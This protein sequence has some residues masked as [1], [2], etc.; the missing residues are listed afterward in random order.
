ME[1]SMKTKVSETQSTTTA[2]NLVNGIISFR[3]ENVPLDIFL[4]L[5][6]RIR[7]LL[8]AGP[9]LLDHMTVEERALVVENLLERHPESGVK[10]IPPP[11]MSQADASEPS[12]PAQRL[13][14]QPTRLPK[15]Y[16]HKKMRDLLQPMAGLMQTEILEVVR[17]TFPHHKHSNEEVMRIY[18]KIH[19]IR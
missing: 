9:F 18:N 17:K 7:T 11:I 2:D 8:G 16:V 14:G 10:A 1:A 13:P 12:R 19:G 5:R 6:G 3:L 15:V 4:G